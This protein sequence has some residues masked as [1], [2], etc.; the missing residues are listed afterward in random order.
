MVLTF[1]AAD[2]TV[3]L[4]RDDAGTI[5][6]AVGSG[7]AQAC[8]A[9]TL[10]NIAQLTATGSASADTLVLDLTAGSFARRRRRDL[11]ARRRPRGAGGDVFALRL[12]DDDNVVTGGTLGADLDE[13]GTPDLTWSATEQLSVTAGSRRR[14]SRVRRRRRRPRRCARPPGGPLQRRRRRHAARRRGGRHLRRQHRRGRRH[15]RRP[16]APR[17]V[18]ASTGS[19]TTARAARA[20]SSARCRGRHRRLGQRH[21]DRQ[22]ARQRAG[23]RARA[24]TQ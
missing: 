19:P 20:I 6:F 22:P 7:A 10:A 11:P 1:A 4:S 3:T 16:S 2:D 12:P 5:R 8:G 21:A 9:A 14:R 17:S 24:T 23:R 15:L 18:R 13:D